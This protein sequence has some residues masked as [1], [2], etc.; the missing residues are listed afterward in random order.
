MSGCAGMFKTSTSC[1]LLAGNTMPLSQKEM[2]L[3]MSSLLAR[4]VSHRRISV[5][6]LHFF[7]GVCS[8]VF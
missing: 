6:K 7:R 3:G 8:T 5:V 4:Q 1:P 2:C